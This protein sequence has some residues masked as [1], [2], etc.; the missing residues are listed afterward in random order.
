MREREREIL[1]DTKYTVKFGIID[2]T[3]KYSIELFHLFAR[4]YI[5][6]LKTVLA[7]T[8]CSFF[9]LDFQ[10]HIRDYGTKS[11]KIMSNVRYS[12]KRSKYAAQ[13]HALSVHYLLW[14]SLTKL[15]EVKFLSFQYAWSKILPFLEALSRL[16]LVITSWTL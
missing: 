4:Y 12:K 16:F 3:D 8:D 15:N 14:G 13:I 7:I 6:L 2:L 11:T 1:Q 10:Q 5:T 9:V